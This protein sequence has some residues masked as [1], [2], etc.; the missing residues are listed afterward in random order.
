MFVKKTFLSMLFV[1]FLV[2][3]TACSGGEGS[4]GNGGSTDAKN[5]TIQVASWNL[6]AD[7]LEKTA[8]KFI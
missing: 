4:S 1:M 2:L 7:A 5:K 6:A 8:A 3:T